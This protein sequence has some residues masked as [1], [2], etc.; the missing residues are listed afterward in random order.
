MRVAIIGRSELMYNTALL[1]A[2]LGYEI[3][4]VITA[5]ESPEYI[6]TSKHF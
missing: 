2:K 6:I 1:I 4:L 3:P 5:K